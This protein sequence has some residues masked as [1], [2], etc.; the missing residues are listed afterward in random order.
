M[1]RQ[2]GTIGGSGPAE[3]RVRDA[4]DNLT[5]M[6]LA[7]RTL[8]A[9]P[10]TPA[11]VDQCVELRRVDWRHYEDL[12]A[13]RGEASTPR[14]TY[15]R[16]TLWIM[17]PSKEHETTSR[18]FTLLL[19]AY[20]EERGVDLRAAGSWTLKNAPERGAEADE[21]FVIGAEAR[22]IPHLV[23]EIVWGAELGDK[24][25]V[26]RGLGVPEVWIW[27]RDRILVHVL[28]GA[29]YE[30]SDHSVLMPDLDLTLLA[31]LVTRRDQIVAIRELRTALRR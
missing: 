15:L 9:P 27:R 23:I 7:A 12:L 21:S 19:G 3:W 17:S 18:M 28:R 24:L 10:P 8:V 30:S 2:R 11:S 4:R 13:V 29:E 25:E 31:R 16:G 22:D 1:T 26:Y 14:L 5:G 6:T 20:A